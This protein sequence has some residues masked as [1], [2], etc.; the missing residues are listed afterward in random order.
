MKRMAEEMQRLVVDEATFMPLGQYDI[1][2]AYS[3][4]LAGVLDAPMPL[5]WNVSKAGR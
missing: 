3:T 4:K 5:F 1:L 2:T